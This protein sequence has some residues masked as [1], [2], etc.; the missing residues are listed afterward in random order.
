MK[1]KKKKLTVREKEL[2]RVKQIIYRERKKGLDVK[3]SKSELEKMTTAQLKKIK[4]IT[5]RK[6]S[7]G[8]WQ[9][10]KVSGVEFEKKRKKE[11]SLKRKLR[12]GGVIE[13]GAPGWSD[14]FINKVLENLYALCDEYDKSV[15]YTD[16]YGAF[17]LRDLLDEE[18]TRY[19]RKA[20]AY[21]VE[22][23]AYSNMETGKIIIQSSD[24]TKKQ[25]NIDILRM[26]IRGSLPSDV[27]LKNDRM[28]DEVL[29]IQNET[30]DDIY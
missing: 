30:D 1:N 23:H 6:Q 7:T 24:R 12:K 16:R 4:P 26:N 17:L 20:V 11:L 2:K 25:L 13:I 5:V 3:I 10:E 8:Y 9:G 15:E 21:S 22:Q 29:Y 19:G 14:G 28:Y 18:I 27:E